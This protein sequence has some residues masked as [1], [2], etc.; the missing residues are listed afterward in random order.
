MPKT[1]PFDRRIGIKPSKRM[2]G[3]VPRTLLHKFHHGAGPQKLRVSEA[4]L[5]VLS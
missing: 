1:M 4:S 3:I 2:F 5:Y